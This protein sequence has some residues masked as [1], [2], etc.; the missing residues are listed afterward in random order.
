VV[1]LFIKIPVRP[2]TPLKVH[3]GHAEGTA[4][5]A[6]LPGWLSTLLTMRWPPNYGWLSGPSAVVR[7]TVRLLLP[8]T[9]DF[10]EGAGSCHDL[11]LSIF[12]MT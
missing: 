7:S 2:P 11:D 9:M 3:W 5:L 4:L 12:R 8:T 6:L 1:S 10:T